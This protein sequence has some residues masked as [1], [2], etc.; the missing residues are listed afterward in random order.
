MPCP[1]S[2]PSPC[3]APGLPM[4]SLT[5]HRHMLS[6]SGFALRAGA[7]KA[8]PLCAACRLAGKA[9]ERVLRDKERGRKTEWFYAEQPVAGG[10]EEGYAARRPAPADRRS[11][12]GDGGCGQSVFPVRTGLHA[13]REILPVFCGADPAGTCF[14]AQ[15]VYAEDCGAAPVQTAGR[16]SRHKR[17]VRRPEA[18]GGRAA[19]EGI[20]GT[21]QEN[22]FFAGRGMFSP[23]FFPVRRNDSATFPCVT[24]CAPERVFAALFYRK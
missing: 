6:A 20:S 24:V 1:R 11:R 3:F 5:V 18:G 7:G 21:V 22:I 19:A 23:R 8:R 4:R 10:G 16:A 14:P 9:V 17:P 2:R 15:S 12:H 13:G